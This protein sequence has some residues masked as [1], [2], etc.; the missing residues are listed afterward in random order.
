MT[1]EKLTKTTTK[2]KKRVGRGQSSGKGKTASRGTKG[3]KKRGKIKLSFEG[4]QL[5][6]QRRLPQRRGLG[7]RPISKAITITTNQLNLLPAKSLVNHE[8]LIQSGLLSFN[9]KRVKIKIVARGSLEK[10]LK[11]ALPTSKKAESVI[12]KA[13]GSLINENPS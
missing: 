7:N 9:L 2:S 10:S 1:L 12:K 5:P 11:V 8:I 4:G 13:G 6:L 3:Q